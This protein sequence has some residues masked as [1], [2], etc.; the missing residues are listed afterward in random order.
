M[1]KRNRTVDTGAVGKVYKYKAG[2][3]V[4]PKRTWNYRHQ[5][6]EVTT[7]KADGTVEVDKPYTRK[8]LKKI[9]RQI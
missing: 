1:K 4:K 3:P 2:K 8:E 7:T 5:A 6:S 9:R